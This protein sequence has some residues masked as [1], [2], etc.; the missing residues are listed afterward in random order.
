MSKIPKKVLQQAEKVARK[1]EN[2]NVPMLSYDDNLQDCVCY[3]LEHDLPDDKDEGYYY[4][5]FKN[6]MRDKVKREKYRTHGVLFD[7]IGSDNDIILG[8]VNQLPEKQKAVIEMVFW[9]KMTNKEIAIE[10]K[11]TTRTIERL[12]K[13]A[14]ANLRKKLSN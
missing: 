1:F 13:K 7:N 3:Y 8:I 12:R 5:A 14:Y 10:L 11:V 4:L 2:V 9:G 6:C